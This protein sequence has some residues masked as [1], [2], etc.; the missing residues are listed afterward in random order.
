MRLEK[1]LECVREG[2]VPPEAPDGLSF[3]GQLV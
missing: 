2:M 1:F 3:R